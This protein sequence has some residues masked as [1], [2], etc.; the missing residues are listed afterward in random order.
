MLWKHSKD[1]YVSATR[2]TPATLLPSSRSTI[3]YSY[4]IIVF[5]NLWSSLRNITKNS[6]IG[7][8]DGVYTIQILIL[9]LKSNAPNKFLRLKLISINN[10]TLLI[11][12][13]IHFILDKPQYIIFTQ[14]H[15]YNTS[16]LSKYYF[17][18]YNL[19]YLSCTFNYKLLPI[20]MYPN[21]YIW[22]AK[23]RQFYFALLFTHCFVT[24]LF[25]GICN[26]IFS[27]L[28]T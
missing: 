6:S 26:Y 9:F 27:H 3:N 25:G 12:T 5:N 2:I 17:R 18:Q 8:Q 11:L 19:K 21:I 28:T 16:K 4:I 15:F 14:L 24:D 10:D 1:T 7:Y 20:Y 13:L 23:E 22:R